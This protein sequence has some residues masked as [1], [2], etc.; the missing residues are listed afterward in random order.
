[1]NHSERRLTYWLSD[2][3]L[4]ASS[5]LSRIYSIDIRS[6]SL[7]E[8]IDQLDRR[9]LFWFS[10]TLVLICSAAARFNSIDVRSLTLDE[11]TIVVFAQ[12]ILEKGYPYVY[13]G[14][15]EV[16]LAT[17]EIVP[18]FMALSIGILGLTD[19][20]V[21]LPAALFGLGTTYLIFSTAWRW[22]DWRVAILA[23]ILYALSPWAIFWATNAFHPSQMQFFAMLTIIQ[24]HKI[25][26]LNKVEPRTYYLTTFFFTCAYL[27]WEGIGFLLPILLVV[28]ILM[29]WGD[30][31]WLKNRHVWI[32]SAIIVFVVVAQGIRRVLL[33]KSYLMV[34]SGR[35]DVS[36]PEFVFTKTY[37]D[38]FFYI[39]ELFMREGHW[40]LTGLFIIG[41]FYT[42]RSI[43]FR[44]VYILTIVAV[45]FMTNFLGYYSAHYIY[46]ALP[47]FFMAVSVVTFQLLQ[48]VTSTTFS[49]TFSG[50]K[51]ARR[52][53][54]CMLIAIEIGASSA[55]GPKLWR[56]YGDF[57]DLGRGDM[58]PGLAS[59]DYRG[60][61][62]TMD[63]LSKP[64]D[65][66]IN[67]APF[68]LRRY[69]NKSGD[70]FL[71]NYTMQK[72]VYNAEGTSPYYMDKYAGN[73][74][75]RSKDELLDALYNHDRVWL[76][77]A[78]YRP[79][80][81]ILNVETLEFIDKYM[82]LVDESYDGKL[83]LWEK[84]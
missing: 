28:I 64:G 4:L 2:A 22:F 39:N 65:A 12:S 16:Q 81:D 61:I 56:T 54:Y 20:A 45:F 36:L 55:Y 24:A 82:T 79:L 44:F 27:S 19:V 1:V 15:M 13:V 11:S 74:T 63:R 18:Y 7:I 83:Y 26:T 72:L 76:L 77:A 42:R 37:Y 52:I 59:I 46:Y 60:L 29:R 75:L 10:A 57:S 6:L 69:I 43:N 23:G 49:D 17:Y 32:A 21:R 25:I 9:L 84:Y 73:I 70:Y 5:L 3:Q 30:W 14:S 62:E 68:T 38:P 80:R 31:G 34:G 67:F 48:S 8:R 50:G 40:I 58:R 35:G 53:S 47:F 41:I 78:P 66:I 71:Q 33:Q 51:L